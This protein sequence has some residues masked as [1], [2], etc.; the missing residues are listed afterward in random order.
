MARMKSMRNLK[1]QT[2]C[3]KEERV[4]SGKKVEDR[5]KEMHQTLWMR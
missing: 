4:K 2:A 3:E 1:Q 5:R